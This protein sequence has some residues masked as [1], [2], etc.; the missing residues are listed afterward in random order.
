MNC[1]NCNHPVREDFLFCENCGALLDKTCDST[2]ITN[3]NISLILQSPDNCIDFQAEL[4]GQ[5]DWINPDYTQMFTIISLQEDLLAQCILKESLAVNLQVGSFVHISGTVKS[6][7]HSSLPVI[8]VNSVEFNNSTSTAEADSTPVAEPEVCV[9]IET[10]DLDEINIDD[11]VL[12]GFDGFSVDSSDNTSDFATVEIADS[13]TSPDVKN[14]NETSSSFTLP[15]GAVTAV[16]SISKNK[17]V[18]QDT[19]QNNQIATDSPAMDK[20]AASQPIEYNFKN[21][22]NKIDKYIGRKI[23]LSG[24]VTDITLNEEKI[25]SLVVKEKESGYHCTLNPTDD[26]KA[27]KVSKGSSVTVSGIVTGKINSFIP[28]VE[29]C[30]IYT[31]SS[32]PAANTKPVQ[33]VEKTKKS[34]PPKSISKVGEKGNKNKL[35][36]AFIACC[37]VCAIAAFIVTP[38]DVIFNGTVDGYFTAEGSN[39]RYLVCTDS[40]TGD[41]FAVSDQN[42]KE[43]LYLSDDNK[44]LLPGDKI[45]VVATRNLLTKVNIDNNSIPLIDTTSIRITEMFDYGSFAV[46]E[47]LT[48]NQYIRNTVLEANQYISFNFEITDDSTGVIYEANNSATVLFESTNILTAGTKVNARVLSADACPTID[49]ET[50]PTLPDVFITMPTNNSTT[51]SPMDEVLYSFTGTVNDVI[52]LGDSI[53]TEI[54]FQ[55]NNMHTV[56]ALVPTANLPYRVLENDIAEVEITIDSIVY[57]DDGTAIIMGDI[58]NIEFTEIVKFSDSGKS[59]YDKMM[60]YPD[61]YAGQTFYISAYVEKIETIDSSDSSGYKSYLVTVRENGC[62]ETFSNVFADYRSESYIKEN[63]EHKDAT[64]RI[65]FNGLYEN[66]TPDY[67][68]YGITVSR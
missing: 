46:S 36:L 60:R 52:E 1:K 4:E 31:L 45:N 57:T 59:L 65:V 13:D 3:D 5:I 24:V 22:A 32:P 19:T 15:S 39:T 66:G 55:D 64:A 43:E 30:S 7:L 67:D 47:N 53:T 18:P 35:I 17:K 16:V 58:N 41:S 21:V 38:R 68:F 6:L 37:V 62:S 11:M 2:V 49:F 63:F 25:I 50:S 51:I 8:D 54:W 56:C 28:L 14:E 29:L 10:I 44:Y 20:P 33:P 27:D 42:D 61:K 26:V 34:T 9:D 12:D 40:T 23:Q 48:Y